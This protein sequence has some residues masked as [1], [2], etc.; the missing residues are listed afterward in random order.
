MLWQVEGLDL[1]EEVEIGITL[2]IGQ[3]FSQSDTCDAARHEKAGL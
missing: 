2:N 3:D 1:R